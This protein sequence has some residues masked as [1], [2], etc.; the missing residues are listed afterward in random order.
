[1]DCSL[2]CLQSYQRS[3][4][5]VNADFACAGD[6][7]YLYLHNNSMGSPISKYYNQ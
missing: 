3:A 1:M 4:K 5:S 7:S 6:Y 2:L